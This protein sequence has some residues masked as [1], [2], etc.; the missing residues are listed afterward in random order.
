MQT[1][2]NTYR[3]P[4]ELDP[5]I[6]PYFA[7]LNPCILDIEAT[8]LAPVSSE[9]VMCA[10]LIPTAQGIQIT[11][12]FA[13][14]LDEE[15]VV[16]QKILDFLKDHMIDMLVTYNGLTYDIPY[17]NKRLEILGIDSSVRLYNFDL[18]RFFRFYTVLKN[19]LPSLSQNSIEEFY[20][21]L[22]DRI[23]TIDGG[24]FPDH[25][26]LYQQNHSET[27][28]DQMY[29][30]NREDVYQLFKILNYASRDGFSALLNSGDIHSAMCN[31]GFP[32]SQG[33]MLIEPYIKGDSLI[34]AGKQLLLNT[35]LAYFE[36]GKTVILD[37]QSNNYQITVPLCHRASDVYVD[38]VE[39]G[40]FEDWPSQELINGFIILSQDGQK[41]NAAIAALSKLIVDKAIAKYHPIH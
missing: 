35:S 29:T 19:Q 24:I 33:Q 40:V 10:M 14:S 23:D 30:H 25:Y 12:Y 21:I 3:I 41:N 36:D 28:L 20:G 9:L 39:L 5:A 8:G 16:L 27:L 2:S 18:Y 34:I 13:E 4:W 6:E 31:M 37:K 32:S 26:A 38:A 7:G 1:V 15:N 22:Q 11:Q 17:I